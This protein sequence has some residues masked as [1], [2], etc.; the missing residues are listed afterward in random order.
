ME[1]KDA[2]DAEKTDCQSKLFKVF[3]VYAHISCMHV[4]LSKLDKGV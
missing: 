4:S 2:T 3:D 1:L